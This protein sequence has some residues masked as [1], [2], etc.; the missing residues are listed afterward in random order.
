MILSCPGW[1]KLVIK[2]LTGR[3]SIANESFVE[4]VSEVDDLSKRQIDTIKIACQVARGLHKFGEIKGEKEGETVM[5][6]I[7]EVTKL[8]ESVLV[9]KGQIVRTIIEAFEKADFLKP[10]ANQDRQPI[11]RLEVLANFTQFVTELRS[12]HKKEHE[13]KMDMSP[14]DKR[15]VQALLMVAKKMECDWN[16]EA[17]FQFRRLEE[18]M[19]KMSDQKWEPLVMEMAHDCGFVETFEDR[20]AGRCVKFVPDKL[21]FTLKCVDLCMR[22]QRQQ[23]K[24]KTSLAS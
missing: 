17:V 13:K 1:L 15:K 16:E 21:Q 2:D 23:R 11:E 14:Q 10:L 5:V 3:V 18:V 19:E 7:S 22:L 9:Y 12:S 8:T 4:K 6:S 24:E 20:E